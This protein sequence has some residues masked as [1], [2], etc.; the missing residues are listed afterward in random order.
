MWRVKEMLSC[1]IHFEKGKPLSLE[2]AHISREQVA[3][4]VMLPEKI[5]RKRMTLSSIA[6]LVLPVFSKS[7]W[8]GALELRALLR[9]PMQK[10]MVI[11]IPMP[12][13]TLRT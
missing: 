6:T 7:T 3:R 10:S 11:S 8:Y 4:A 2:N 9:S 1:E 5:R 12:R 13:M